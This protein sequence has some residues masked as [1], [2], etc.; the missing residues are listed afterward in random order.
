ML[1]LLNYDYE[2][3]DY[4]YEHSLLYDNCKEILDNMVRG[5]RRKESDL[6]PLSRKLLGYLQINLKKY[7]AQKN[8]TQEQ[9]AEDSGLHVST[10][11]GLEQGDMPNITIDTYCALVLGLG[12]SRDY[13]ALLEK[14]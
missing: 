5:H 4:G 14:P 13:L 1:L 9:L 12:M 11:A 10:I 7:R 6:K 2:R 8:K 3:S